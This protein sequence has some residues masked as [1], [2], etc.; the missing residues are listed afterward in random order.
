ME[1]RNVEIV[2]E[3]VSNCKGCKNDC[4]CLALAAYMN[5]VGNEEFTRQYEEGTLPNDIK[6][7][8]ISK[9]NK[10]NL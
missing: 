9:K 4:P 5:Q 7:I 3:K 1:K 6:E 10:M 2:N 8:Y